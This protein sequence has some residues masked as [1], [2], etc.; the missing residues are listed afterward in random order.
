MVVS[1]T[2]SFHVGA[3]IDPDC[4]A[5]DKTGLIAGQKNCRAGDLRGLA[6]PPEG[7]EVNEALAEIGWLAGGHIRLNI[8]R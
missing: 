2:F 1:F 7:R 3:T 6:K 4:L 8:G 5:G